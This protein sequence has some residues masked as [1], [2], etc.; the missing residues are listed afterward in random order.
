[1]ELDR[2]P[3]AGDCR[4]RGQGWQEQPPRE[5]V[6]DRADQIQV[7]ARFQ[8]VAVRA[9]LD[10]RGDEIVI[11]VHRQ[12]NDSGFRAVSPELLE[13][14]KAIELGHGDI[15]HDHVG[16]EAPCQVQRLTAVGRSSHDVKSGAQIAAD[17]FQQ[18]DVIVGKE[19]ARSGRRCAV[20]GEPCR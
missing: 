1:M 12:E 9:G 8:H 17:R 10:R 19:D 3:V 16:P 15:Q 4:E 13:R 18:A 20:Q 14:L 7:H 11:P 5:G 6:V 2:V